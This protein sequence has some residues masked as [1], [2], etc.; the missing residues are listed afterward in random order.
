M[1][2]E[3]H[4]TLVAQNKNTSRRYLDNVIEFPQ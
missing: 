4:S 1:C 3:I 2:Q